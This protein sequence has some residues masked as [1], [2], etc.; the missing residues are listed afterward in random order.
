MDLI[1]RTAAIECLMTN[2]GWHDEDGREVDDA[3]DKRA[4][5]SDLINGIPTVDA[6]PVVH[7]KWIWMSSTYDRSPCEARYMCS[8]CRHETITHSIPPWEKYCPN[9]GAKN[10]ES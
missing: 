5:I 1:L 9:C 8:K 10:T 6:A 3:D 2:M 7:G 4:I